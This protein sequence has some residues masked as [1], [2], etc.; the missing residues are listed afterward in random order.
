M[1]VCFWL[2][3]AR[4]V[5]HIAVSQ[6]V[7]HLGSDIGISLPPQPMIFVSTSAKCTL[8]R[9]KSN[10]QS[11][12]RL[13]ALLQRERTLNYLSVIDIKLQLNASSV[14]PFTPSFF[15]PL[16]STTF[17]PFVSLFV[18]LIRSHDYSPLN[19]SLMMWEE[20]LAGSEGSSRLNEAACCERGDKCSPLLYGRLNWSCYFCFKTVDFHK[21]REHV[22]QWWFCTPCEN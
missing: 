9:A 20:D 15:I 13:I 3:P 10:S 5:P 7:V 6:D 21:G 2:S 16:V 18:C 11:W 4:W 17:I 14:F 8:G 1:T 19:H 22:I 12:F